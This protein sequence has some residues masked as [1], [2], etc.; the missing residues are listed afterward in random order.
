MHVFIHYFKFDKDNDS[1]YDEWYS[2]EEELMRNELFLS[3]IRYFDT[4]LDSGYYFDK[5]SS[6]TAK[7]LLGL[8]SLI[9]VD[10][11]SAISTYKFSDMI[12]LIREIFKTIYR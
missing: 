11:K 4:I 3:N 7:D 1:K 12:K 8:I 10:K 2:Y 5:K 9:L 6:F